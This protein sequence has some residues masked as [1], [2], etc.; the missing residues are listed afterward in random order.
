MK[1]QDLIDKAKAD[2]AAK[3]AAHNVIADE[4]GVLRSAETPDEVVISEKRAAKNAIADEVDAI[5]RQIAEL[6]AEQSRDEAMERLAKE[7]T[8]AAPRPSYDRAAR[9]GQEKRTYSPET[10]RTGAQFLQDVMRNAMFGDID[11]RE[12]LARHMSEERVERGDYLARAAVG[13]S[14]F[15]GLTIPQYLTDLVAPNA[16]AGRPL[17]DVSRKHDLP[18]EGMT[19]NISKVTTGTTAAAHTENT[20][21]TESSID[22]TLLTLN[23]L[24]NENWQSVSRAAAERSTGALDVTI[25]DLVRGYHTLLDNRLINE[26]TVGLTNKATAIAYTDASPTAAELY[27]KILAGLAAV[28]A[29]LLDQSSSGSIAVMH[30]RRWYWMQS[31]VGTSW[32]FI[33]QAG[34]AQQQG[35]VNYGELYGAG[36][37]GLLPN[38]TPVIVD[39]NIATNF[40][41]N[42]DEIYIVNANECHLWEDPNAPMFI[43]ADQA[44]ATALNIPLVV[45]GFF[46]FTFDRYAGAMQKVN[47]TGLILPVF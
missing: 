11:S 5:D 19:V 1:L 30:S 24:T 14:A 37:R 38:G 29:A 44:G 18:A 31:Q 22:D 26:A 4:L 47:G 17:A 16:K 36:Y 7:S 3:V 6:E 45:Y 12:R 28:E 39:N 2:R 41:T 15:A 33:G 42:E 35:G 40:G 23:V 9:V 25:D 10:D 20:A 43:R 13:T 46:A 8:P 27:P 34:L 32:P 21:V